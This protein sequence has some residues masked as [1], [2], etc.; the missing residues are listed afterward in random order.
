VRSI[1]S[2]FARGHVL[3]REYPYRGGLGRAGLPAAVVDRDETAVADARG[4]R[5]DPAGRHLD[6]R[7]VKLGV[8][9]DQRLG[10]RALG[11]QPR[12]QHQLLPE[13]LPLEELLGNGRERRAVIA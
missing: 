12:Q 3:R 6:L 1:S 11:Q 13:R 5:G 7:P 2:T 9:Q 10:L 8:P 4:W